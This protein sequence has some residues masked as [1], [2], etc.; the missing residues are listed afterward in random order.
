M[1]ER[2]QRTGTDEELI[3]IL[4][5]ISVVS[6]R[7]AR[8]DAFDAFIRTVRDVNT[9]PIEFD[10][11]LWLKVIDTVMVKN[12]GTLAFKFQNGMNLNG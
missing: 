7:L 3:D 5:A 10:D 8:A 2:V 4:T 11:R 12:D 6:K 1:N 9:V